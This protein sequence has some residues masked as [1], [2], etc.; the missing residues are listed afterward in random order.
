MSRTNEERIMPNWACWEY[1][2]V[3]MALV[4]LA[5]GGDNCEKEPQQDTTCQMLGDRTCGISPTGSQAVQTCTLVDTQ[6]GSSWEWTID[7]ICTITECCHGRKCIDLETGIN[8]GFPNCESLQEGEECAKDGHCADGMECFDSACCVPQ[9]PP[10]TCGDNGCGGNCGPCRAE[11]EIC[12]DGLCVCQPTCGANDCGDDG[13]GGACAQCPDFPTPN[14]CID[15]KCECLLDNGDGTLSNT[16]SELTWEGEAHGPGPRS[17]ANEYCLSLELA[18]SDQWRLP[19]Q[20]EL[21]TIC[22]C[23]YTMLWTCEYGMPDGSGED[24]PLLLT[25]NCY[26]S[27]AAPPDVSYLCVH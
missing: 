11:S 4:L 21:H 22:D 1:S 19:T 8:K 6:T 15:G 18:G 27:I 12:K 24:K 2:P 17:E 25:K 16:I 26:F 23:G 7:K 13:C 3:L 5:C 14:M 20:D 10:N 9:C